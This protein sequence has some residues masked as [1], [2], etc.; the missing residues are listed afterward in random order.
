MATNDEINACI[1]YYL[2]KVHNS[3]GKICDHHTTIEISDEFEYDSFI[4]HPDYQRSFYAHD[5]D[6]ISLIFSTFENMIK[7]QIFHGKKIRM[8]YGIRNDDYQ[9]TQKWLSVDFLKKMKV[10]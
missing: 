5:R 8:V 1:E 6:K 2:D 3:H 9:M 7:D 4:V 10:F